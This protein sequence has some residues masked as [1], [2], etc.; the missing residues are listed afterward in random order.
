MQFC[1]W[2]FLNARFIT[3]TGTRQNVEQSSMTALQV[4]NCRNSCEITKQL[5]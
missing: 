4:I 5:G 1:Y 2:I 3:Q